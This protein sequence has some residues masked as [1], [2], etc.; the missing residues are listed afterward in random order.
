MTIVPGE[1]HIMKRLIIILGFGAFAALP[2]LALAHRPATRAEKSAMVYHA[3][4]HYAPGVQV[5]E[6]RSF[7]LHCA[8]AVIS[9]VVKGSQWGAYTLINNSHCRKY[10]GGDS[11]FEHKINGR[12]YVVTERGA[13][14]F[15]NV[16]GVPRRIGLDLLKGLGTL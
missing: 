16:S 5:D 1:S 6:P 3:G 12:W 8:K 15:F 10:Q 4:N 2:A 7:P 11:T 13:G 9:T 14:P